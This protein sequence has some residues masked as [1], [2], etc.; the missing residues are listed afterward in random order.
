[1]FDSPM[2]DFPLSGKEMPATSAGGESTSA[3]KRPVVT[4]GDPTSI[5]LTMGSVCSTIFISPL[6]DGIRLPRINVISLSGRLQNRLGLFSPQ[7]WRRLRPRPGPNR[8]SL[9]RNLENFTKSVT[10]L[11]LKRTNFFKLL[12]PSRLVIR[13]RKSDVNW[14]ISQG[15]VGAFEYLRQS[16]PSVALLD[17]FSTAAYKSGQHDGI[18]EGCVSCHQ[19]NR[20]TPEIQE[21]GGKLTSDMAMHWRRF[22]TIHYPRMLI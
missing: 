7:F 5:L 3:K 16:E 11:S 6:C 15:L 1:M 8:L 20:V 22:T 21:D 2:G 9:R 4:L 19:T 18:Y 13:R 12:S 14:L 17:R 10:P